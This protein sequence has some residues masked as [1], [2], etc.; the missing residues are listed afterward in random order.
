MCRCLSEMFRYSID[1]K[2]R[3]VRLYD[4]VEHVK[5]YIYLQSIR[6]SN[7]FQFVCDI[8]EELLSIRLPRFILQPLV[9]NAILHGI[10]S[11]IEMGIIVIKVQKNGDNL[12]ISIEDNGVGIAQESLEDILTVINS[13]T[14][15]DDSQEIRY[16]ALNN[17]N[18]RLL[19]H[20]GTEYALKIKSQ[21]GIGTKVIVNIPINGN[22]ENNINWS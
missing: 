14:I 19:L 20:Y 10:Y 15:T 17:V 13:D 5:N 18:K 21:P 4:E 7:K 2:R 1:N 9:E 16:A 11:M 12:E 8:S 3:F 6:Y 22:R